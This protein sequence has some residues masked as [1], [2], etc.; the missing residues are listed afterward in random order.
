METNNSDEWKY[1]DKREIGVTCAAFNGG[2]ERKGVDLGPKFV[3]DRG[4]IKQLEDMDFKVVLTDNK[5]HDYEEFFPSSDP[6]IG[7]IKNP[8]S[9]GIVSKML[10][11]QVYDHVKQGRLALQIGGDHSI[12]IG[13][14]FGMA[15]A[16]KEKFGCDLKVVWVD[17]HADINTPES[18]TTG[19][20]HG[21]PLSFLLGINTEKLEGL[22]WV[23]PC[24]KPENLVYVGLRDVDKPE[25]DII[26]KYNIKAFSMHE[27]DRYGIGQV[28]EMAIEHL[29]KGDNK[30]SPIH[31]SFDIDALDPS[32]AACTGTPVRGG[33]TF[34]EGHYICEVLHATG[35]LVG[36]DMVELNPHLGD[37]LEESITIGCSLVRASFGE[38]LL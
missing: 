36:V 16:V 5:I 37:N 32:V 25:K 35:R 19:H 9:V 18:T 2:Q 14:V 3:L 34:R 30:D 23:E 10:A 38:S 22:E 17:A 33:L 7:V 11:D 24:L 4:I 13:I 31:L 8:R 28:M 29:S 15:R 6:P 26:K 12:A 20:L 1:V 27:V 21:M